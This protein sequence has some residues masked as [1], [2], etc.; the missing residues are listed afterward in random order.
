[1]HDQSTEMVNGVK[2][3]LR[4]HF[5]DVEFTATNDVKTKSM[6]F[7]GNGQ[8]RYRLQISERFL[9]AEDGVVKSLFRLEEWNLATVLRDARTKLVTLATTGVH[10]TVRAR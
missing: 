5:P 9:R 8:P 2:A 7:H 6:L 3:Y 1:M 10:I 4:A